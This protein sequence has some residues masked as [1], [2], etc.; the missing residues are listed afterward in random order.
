MLRYGKIMQNI[1]QWEDRAR[2]SVQCQLI[3]YIMDVFAQR[4]RV[5]VTT[6]WEMA[7]Y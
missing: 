4:S 5:C 1:Y 6:D 7:N 2:A 3:F